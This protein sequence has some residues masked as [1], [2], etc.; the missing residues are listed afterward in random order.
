MD[1]KVNILVVDDDEPLLNALSGELRE[2]G[3]DVV[4]ADDGDTAVELL[5]TKQFDVVL[6]DIRMPR[7]NG[8]EALKVIKKQSPKTKVVMLTGVADLKLAMDSRKFGAEDF[9]EKPYVLETLLFK[10]RQLTH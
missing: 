5:P 4:T 2:A 3:F 8:I 7:M 9:V 10:L 1:N 6:L